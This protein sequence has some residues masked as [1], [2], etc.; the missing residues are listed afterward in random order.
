M[1]ITQDTSLNTQNTIDDL[2]AYLV[3]LANKLQ[4]RVDDVSSNMTK[5]LEEMTKRIE[6]LERGLKLME[7]SPANLNVKEPDL[8]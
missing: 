6:T 1:T 4:T 2:P 5:K 8:E 3:G 7:E